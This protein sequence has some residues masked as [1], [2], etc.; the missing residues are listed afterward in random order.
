MFCTNKSY[1]ENK[2]TVFKNIVA[3]VSVFFFTVQVYEKF[4]YEQEKILRSLYIFAYI[5]VSGSLMVTRSE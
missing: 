2:S 4:M 1:K 3:V 5:T